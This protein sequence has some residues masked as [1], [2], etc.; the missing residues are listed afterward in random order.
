MSEN[1]QAAPAAKAPAARF[2]GKGLNIGIVVAAVV[3]V[4]GLALWG[5]QLSGGL[6]QT[7][8]RNFDSWGLYIT[9]FMFLVGLSAGGLI[10]SSVPRAFGMKGF[11]GISKIAVWTSIC[12]TVLAV[13]FVVIDLGQ[14]L[15]LWELFAYSNLGSPLMWDIAVISIYLIL[16]VVYL[17]ATL[18]AE[19][20]KVSEKALRVISVVALVTAV[21]VH[22]V[23]AWIFGLQQAH[24]FWHTALLAP[25]FVSSALVCGV[26]LVLVVVIALRKA[27]Y[28]ELD[29]ANVVKLRQDAG[30]VR[31]RRPVLLRL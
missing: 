12:C 19:A 18:R 26:A 20:G 27:G 15:R 28:L 8:M 14:P 24:E 22:S 31:R 17:W 1:T 2:G 25:W 3:T 5:M 29:Q 16:S 9:M 13:G 30:R 11:G 23:T 4:A 7:G 6:V 10:I 21:L